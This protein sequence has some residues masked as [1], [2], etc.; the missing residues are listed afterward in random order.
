MSAPHLYV[1]ELDAEECA[2]AVALTSGLANRHEGVEEPTF[3]DVAETYAQDLPRRLRAGL[4]HFRLHEPACVCLV[5][6]YPVDDGALGS[7][8]A[9]WR[10]RP[11]SPTTRAGDIFF[12]LC[13]SLLGSPFAWSTKQDGHIMHT[14]TPTRGD[15]AEQLAS[16]SR[17]QLTWHTED[18]FH[19]LR[20]DYLGLMCLRNPDRVETTLACTH[21]VEPAAREHP[22]LFEPRFRIVPDGSHLSSRP[23][24]PHIEIPA[25]LKAR[26]RDRIAR[27]LADPEP[28][29][30][31]FGDPVSPYLRLDQYYTS[32]VAGDE[33]AARALGLL[34][35]SVDNGLKRYALR[36]GEICFID[37]YRVVHGRTAFEARYDGTDRWLRRLNI[38]RDLRRS[39]DLR[40][41]AGSRLVV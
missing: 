5:R 29:P 34:L 23:Q 7:T 19:P 9:H 31:L 6:G 11:L 28:I 30:L 17:T 21:D 3:Q 25:E 12:F 8:P 2:A 26:A 13:G 20:A 14:I 41:A 37:N 32:A 10:E 4:N 40:L 24:S 36:P 1:V 33:V 22:V 16:S 27:M 39:R 15:E 38:T 35:A 18:A